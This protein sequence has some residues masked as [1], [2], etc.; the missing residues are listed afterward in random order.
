[1]TWA[2][3]RLD[4]LIG[5]TAALPPVIATLRLG[6]L[7]EW[8][9][10]WVRKTW[11]P[12]ADAMAEVLNADGTMFGGYLAALADQSLAFAAMTVLPDE[13]TF[14]TTNLVLT[15]VRVA[16]AGPLTIEARVTARTRQIVATR[17][18]L[19][20]ADGELVAEASAQQ[21]LVPMNRRPGV[22]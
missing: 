14:R 20:R 12:A 17:A 8:G 16:S 22:A 19:R 10:G 2:R 9:E 5:G 1:M 18:G 15:F 3:E 21:L 11:K 6:V 4:A 13:M 7:D